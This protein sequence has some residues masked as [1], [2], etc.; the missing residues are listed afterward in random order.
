MAG[1]VNCNGRENGNGGKQ[2]DCAYIVE[3]SWGVYK[4]VWEV[5]KRSYARRINP[6]PTPGTTSDFFPSVVLFVSLCVAY[7]TMS[8]KWYTVPFVSR[9]PR[10]QP[11]AGNFLRCVHYATP[12]F[13]V[14]SWL[15]I[16]GSIML[17][18]KMFLHCGICVVALQKTGPQKIFCGPPLIVDCMAPYNTSSVAMVAIDR[19]GENSHDS[20]RITRTACIR[21]RQLYRCRRP[22]HGGNGGRDTIQ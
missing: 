11:R 15:Y 4:I 18:C 8:P 6:T 9:F 1:V 10:D 14:C 5:P 21:S 3:E 7:A 16:Y 22:L 13:M 17:R 2:D 20:G 19:Y 12:L